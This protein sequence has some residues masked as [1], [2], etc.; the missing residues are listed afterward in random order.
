M[1][2]CWFADIAIQS[3]FDGGVLLAWTKKTITDE[4]VEKKLRASAALVLANLARN[5]DW[6][7][8]YQISFSGVDLT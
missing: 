4:S 1:T 3:L 2:S 6:C 8:P 7:V 5:G